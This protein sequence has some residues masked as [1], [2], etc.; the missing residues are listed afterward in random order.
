MRDLEES[1]PDLAEDV[2]NAKKSRGFRVRRYFKS[3]P[4]IGAAKDAKEPECI[5]YVQ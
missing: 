1:L 3:I 4:I 5:Q 2:P